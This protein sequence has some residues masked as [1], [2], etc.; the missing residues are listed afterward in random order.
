MRKEPE[1]EFVK[2]PKIVVTDGPPEGFG[3]GV[4]DYLN[5]YVRNADAKAGVLIAA[6]LT[7][8]AY[9]LSQRCSQRLMLRLVAGVGEPARRVFGRDGRQRPVYRLH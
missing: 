9:L 7:I 1:G 2:P 8:A 4:N 6:A 5:H 3:K